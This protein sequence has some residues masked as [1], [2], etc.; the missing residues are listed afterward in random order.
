MPIKIKGKI[1]LQGL[2]WHSLP[3][4]YPAFPVKQVLSVFLVAAAASLLSA[5][6]RQG[7]YTLLN[8]PSSL[9]PKE[10]P[11]VTAG[12]HL[13]LGQRCHF[14]LT[15]RGV[16]CRTRART[17]VARSRSPTRQSGE[18]RSWARTRASQREHATS[19]AHANCLRS[20][21]LHC[22]VCSLK[23]GCLA[24]CFKCSIFKEYE[25]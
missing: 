25:K 14:Y 20:A 15:S 11:T 6:G 4:W 19:R 1:L 22:G 8:A 9:L 18:G 24:M 23:H 17:E 3:W 16:A 2:A 12:T 10:T 7:S 13:C 21:G 5:L